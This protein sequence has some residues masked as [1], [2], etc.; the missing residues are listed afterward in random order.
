[1]MNVTDRDKNEPWWIEL[2][3]DLEG[4]L[5]KL[6]M[7]NDKRMS[8]DDKAEICGQIKEIKRLIDSLGMGKSKP[9]IDVE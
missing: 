1:M 3:G 4:R 8:P 7:D 9:K 5:E 2:K 6:R